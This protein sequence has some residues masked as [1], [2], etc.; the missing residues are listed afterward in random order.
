MKSHSRGRTKPDTTKAKK[1]ERRRQKPKPNTVARGFRRFLDSPH[2]EEITTRLRAGDSAE[3]VAAWLHD[4]CEEF[5]NVSDSALIRQL[6]RYR[7]TIAG[8]VRPN[9]AHIIEE[10]A[11]ERSKGFNA[12]RVEIALA[13]VQEHRLGQVLELE[14]QSDQLLADVGEEIDRLSRLAQNVAVS[15]LRLGI[16][17]LEADSFGQPGATKEFGIIAAMLEKRHGPNVRPVLI[18]IGK[19]LHQRLQAMQ[20]EKGR[21]ERQRLASGSGEEEASH[22]HSDARPGD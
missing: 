21:D 9:K 12:L 7:E 17:K 19:K 8:A 6:Y 16:L 15:K 22:T 2:G 4:D 20:A 3:S 11:K 18:D 13:V 5:L 10:L 14:R 1:R